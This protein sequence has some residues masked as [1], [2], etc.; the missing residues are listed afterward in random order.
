[1]DSYISFSFPVYYFFLF[2]LFFLFSC[3]CILFILFIL[4][5]LWMNPV[6]PVILLSCYPVIYLFLTKER[7]L[8][9]DNSL[10]LAIGCWSVP[11]LVRRLQG[12]LSRRLVRHRR[13][14]RTHA[15]GRHRTKQYQGQV[16]TEC[17]LNVPWMFPDRFG[18]GRTF[19][20]GPLYTA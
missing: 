18:Q 1:L 19:H 14:F 9:S 10:Y 17:S 4:F 20:A 8:W 11:L 13:H 3:A 12:P 6:Y 2:F 7:G 5:I 16:R 15:R